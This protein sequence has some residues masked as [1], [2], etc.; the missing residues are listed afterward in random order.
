[1]GI[2][3][4]LPDDVMDDVVL[5]VSVNSVEVL[6]DC[7]VD[8]VCVGVLGIEVGRLL[9]D[10]LEAVVD[11]V[12]GLPDDVTDVVV[13]VISVGVLLASVEDDVAVVGDPELTEDRV[14]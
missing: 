1:M 6:L 11:V 13:G 10:V 8:D 12:I 2:V 14:G 5:D 7:V 9:N 3:G 4:G